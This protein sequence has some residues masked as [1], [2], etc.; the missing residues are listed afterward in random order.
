MKLAPLAALA[1]L[2]AAPGPALAAAPAVESDP[3][4]LLRLA[5]SLIAERR[6]DE[7]LAML[8]W[9]A[10]R[11]GPRAAIA[12]QRG[13]ALDLKG[14]FPAAQQAYAGALAAAP[15]DP[16][17]VQ[18]MALSLGLAGK[19]GAAQLLL[20]R[21]GEGAGV[22]RTRALVH[23]LG[24][25]QADAN[26][27]AMASMSIAEARRMR[28]FYAELPRLPL[29]DRAAAVHFGALPG[30]APTA[31]PTAVPTAIPAPAA[32]QPAQVIVTPVDSPD[33][34]TMP[35]SRTAVAPELLAA[36]PRIWVQLS[37]LADPAGL[38]IEWQRIRRAAGELVEGQHGYV[39]RTGTTN[40]LLI[41]PF[42]TE[43]AARAMI[44]RL[45]AKRL[46]AVLNRTLA[47]AD[48]APLG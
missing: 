18:R 12:I 37:S 26:E 46:A 10:E 33:F 15:N 38:S 24:G 35:A 1:I 8:D 21:L 25:R 42:A 4:A 48:L 14:E 40:R 22:Q 36:R 31:M 2:L 34:A 17:A 23:A 30:D 43:A 7:A 41:G 19:S 32:D 20:Q 44:D 9:A 29:R 13:L 6:L 5:R 39:Q 16:E 28:A 11:G 47:G 45:K 3:L 27:I